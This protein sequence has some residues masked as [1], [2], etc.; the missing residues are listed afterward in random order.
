MKEEI[1]TPSGSPKTSGVNE[2]LI[3]KD[4]KFKEV[5]GKDI[6]LLSGKIEP[7]HFPMDGMPDVLADLIN[8]SEKVY[9]SPLEYFACTLLVACGSVVRKKAK[10]DDGKFINYPQLWIMYIGSSGIGKDAPLKIAFKPIIELDDISYKDY[11]AELDQWKILET[12]A[13]KEKSEIPPKPMLK[14]ILIDDATPESFYPCLQQNGGLTL[15]RDE[16]SGWFSDFGRY[17]KNGEIQRY[18]SLFTNGSFSIN[19]VGKDHIKIS[20]PYYSIIGGIQPEVLPS[21]LKENQLKENGFAQ[22]FLFAYPDN[23]MQPYYNEL[24]PNP[25]FA[26]RYKRL[27]EYLH[28]T[29]FG[30]LTLSSDA[31]DKYIEFANEMVTERNNTKIGYQQ[32]LYSRFRMHVLRIAL[33]LELVK[34]FPYGLNKEKT[35]S[36]ETMSYAIAICRYFI[37]C[38][39]KVEALSFAKT[40]NKFDD[41]RQLAKVLLEKG[42]RQLEI[43]KITGLSQ[44]TIS[45]LSAIE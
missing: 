34:S 1:Q 37:V 23:A 32:A 11:K 29:D 15:H 43:S 2:I 12:H 30:T 39:L 7:N 25:V 45:R 17:S 13:K 24:I 18:L 40:E 9:G 36:L 26:V 33:T 44:P 10:L 22:R 21:T 27:I 14:M 20:E 35:L 5:L 38:G 42:L 19:R 4:M 16:L 8:D 3:N 28:Q 31:K 41:M 6:Q